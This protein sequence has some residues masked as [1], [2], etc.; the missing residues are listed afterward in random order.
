[1]IPV[2]TGKPPRVSA[3]TMVTRLAVWR[4]HADAQRMASH[5]VS[6]ELRRDAVMPPA[7]VTCAW[8]PEGGEDDERRERAG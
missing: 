5:R 8:A 4:A 2:M 7:P 1:M 6:R 3:E